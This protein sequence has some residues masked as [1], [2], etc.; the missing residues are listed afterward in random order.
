MDIN[1][2]LW[3]QGLR[4]AADPGVEDFFA[5][6]SAVAVNAL[7]LVIPFAIFWCVD[8]AKGSVAITSFALGNAVNQFVKNTVCAYRPWV[9]DSRIVASSKAIEGATGYS[10]PSGHTL[11]ATTA[12]G[13]LGWAWRKLVWP[14]VLTGAFVLVSVAT[15]LVIVGVLGV[16]WGGHFAQYSESNMQRLAEQTA[17]SVATAYEDNHGSWYGGT[18][19]SAEMVSALYDTVTVRVERADGSVIYRDT[20]DPDGSTLGPRK[21]AKN[22][23]SAD[24]MVGDEKVGTV[25]VSVYGSDTLLTAADQDLQS[26]T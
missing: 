22:T 23:A 2:L 20:N 21:N 5:T 19:S 13:A 10:F 15:V 26:S 24:I 12:I 6:A 17:E 25:Y 3:L 8:K 1:I 9:R 4:E 14:L 16:F 7:F 18:L 11:T